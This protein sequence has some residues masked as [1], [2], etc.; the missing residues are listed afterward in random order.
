MLSILRIC[1]EFFLRAALDVQFGDAH[2]YC[3]GTKY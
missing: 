2:V 3:Y 1:K